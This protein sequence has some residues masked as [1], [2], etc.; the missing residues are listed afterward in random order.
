MAGTR[1]GLWIRRYWSGSS[2]ST[3]R[4]G[5]LVAKR[6]G[7][8]NRLGF[9]LQLV[10]VRH[11]GAFLGDPL[12]VPPAV[13]DYVAAQLGVA[14]PSCVKRYTE[15]DK[16]RLE[17]QWEIAGVDGFASFA[18]A[19]AGLVQWLD[20]EAW[21]TGDGPRALFYAAVAWLREGK[22]LLPGVTTLVELVATVRQAAEDRLYDT[23][24]TSVTAGQARS[25][26]AILEVPEG[27]RRSQLDLWRRGVRS[28]TGRGMVLALDRV[29]EIA[30]LR[31]READI[32]SV[33]TRRVIELARYGMAA[34]APKLSR[35]PYRRKI[36]TLLATVRWLEV[37]AADDALELFDV[38]M[39]SELIGRAGKA[40]DKEKLRR[41]A[42]YARHAGVLRAAVEVLFEPPMRRAVQ[43]CLAVRAARRVREL[44]CPA[45]ELNDVATEGDSIQVALA[46][47]VGAL[48]DGNGAGVSEA[49]GEGFYGAVGFDTPDLAGAVGGH[50]EASGGIDREAIETGGP[51]GRARAGVGGDVGGVGDLDAFDRR[52][53]PCLCRVQVPAARIDREAVRGRDPSPAA[54]HGAARVDAVDV[55]AE[56]V[57][58]E[59]R[60][61]RGT[62]DPVRLLQAGGPGPALPG[63]GI[64]QQ[65]AGE[66]DEIADQAAGQA[67]AEPGD[68]HPL[69]V[70]REPARAVDPAREFDRLRVWVIHAQHR[71]R[72]PVPELAGEE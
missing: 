57:G 21:T 27:R 30:G 56:V 64:D 61:V 7:D 58:G 35:H 36:A 9:A 24:A 62:G 72:K 49:A 55:R 66:P 39:S 23:L 10:T 38:F 12:D 1:P 6:R 48:P 26:E 13:L 18:S 8:H 50:V 4:T 41:Q 63:V 16:T 52:R 31:M 65:Q 19:E 71:A 51:G 34:K 14:D 43:P 42:G 70:E 17:H 20:D 28:T 59:D 15:R 29:A 2:S 3:T 5:D 54:V 69:I 37:T 32:A 67:V 45:S 25:L 46:E 33:P 68:Q 11:V 40:A 44:A 53:R 22:V 47:A 60:P